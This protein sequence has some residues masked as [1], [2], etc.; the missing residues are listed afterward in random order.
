MARVKTG[1]DGTFRVRLPPGE[2]VVRPLAPP[3]APRRWPRAEPARIKVLPGK[4][5]RLTISFDSGMR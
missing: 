4:F 2:Y 5:A 1:A 3:G